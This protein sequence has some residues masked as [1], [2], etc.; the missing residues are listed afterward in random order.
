MEVRL[1]FKF[2]K[3]IKCVERDLKKKKNICVFFRKSLK[4]A[5]KIT[6]LDTQITSMKFNLIFGLKM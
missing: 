5:R 2:K 1:D 6:M 4:W 3:V